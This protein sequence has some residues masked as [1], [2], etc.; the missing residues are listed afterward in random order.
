MALYVRYVPT[1]LGGGGGGGGVTTVGTLDSNTKSSD[2][3]SIIGSQLFMQTADGTFPG[4]VSAGAQTFAGVKNFSANIFAANLSGTN[5]GDVTIGTANGLSLTGS[6]QVLNLGLSSTSTTGALSNTDWN[7]FNGKQAAGNYITALTGDGTAS[8]P[9][10]AALT[11]AT[12][13]SNVGSFGSAASS[14]NITVNA[15]GLITAASTNSIQ[16]TES[17]VT[18]LVSDLAGKQPIGNYITALTGDVTATGPG[19]VAATIANNVVT[20]AKLAQMTA[21][22]YKGNNTG[23]TAN[24]ADITSTQLTADLNLFTTSLQGLVPAS[25]GGTTNYLRADGTFAAPPG[26]TSGTVTTVSVVSTNGLAGTVA[27]ATTTPAI[28]LSTTVTGILQ[29]NGTAISAA[30]TTGTGAVVLAASPTLTAPALGTPTA[31]VGTNITGTAAGL[32]AGTVTTN[33]NMTGDVTSVGNTTTYAG[34]VPLNKGGTGTNAASANA[35]FNALS[36]MTTGGDI[37]YG[38]AS[39]VAT[40]LANGSSGQFLKS[41]GTTL[42]P[43]WSAV[44]SA[45]TAPTVQ[46][47]LSTGTTTGY[48]FTVSSA[49]ATTGATYTNNGNT[50]TVLGTISAG[51]QLFTSQVAA[52]AASGTLTKTSGT[53]DSTITFSANTPL[54]TYTTPSGPAPS[55]IEIEMCGGGNGGDGQSTG[56]SPGGI[57]TFGANIL[58][59]PGGTVNGGGAAPTVGAGATKI[60]AVKGGTGTQAG[61]AAGLFPGQMGGNNPFGGAGGGGGSSATGQSAVPNSGGGG[62]GGGGTNSVP[63]SAGRDAGSYIKATISSPAATYVYCVGAGG[64]GGTGAPIGGAGG[65]GVIIIREFY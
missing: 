38:G 64:A 59:A 29:G 37:I 33:A 57:T 34:V 26:A 8:G 56:G 30:S 31:L 62:G 11:L 55:Y 45:S 16:I 42:A 14:L 51:T 25:G 12:V 18:N 13:N 50:Y 58:I 4:V 7:I 10:S 63:N 3:A 36:P 27:T 40:R 19:S 39:G 54:A 6:S 21:H 5:S 47:L 44:T 60:Y 43:T 24:A 15:K 52:P 2:A 35:A 53:G 1:S 22:T 65:S 17:Q 61:S 20:N 32:T 41:N 9:G 49:N 23:S 46:S 28:T 48:L